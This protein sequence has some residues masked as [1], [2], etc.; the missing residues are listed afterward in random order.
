MLINNITQKEGKLNKKFII[1]LAILRVLLAFTVLFTHIFHPNTSKNRILLYLWKIKTNHIPTF[2]ILSFYLM[3]NLFEKYSR[4]KLYKRF[5]RLLNE[6]KILTEIKGFCYS[7]GLKL[8]VGASI[9][10]IIFA[11]IPLDCVTK[12]RNLLKRQVEFIC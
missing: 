7:D 1:S 9:I 11:V 3:G 4:K 2:F 5:K 6:C 10:F 8:S 12:K